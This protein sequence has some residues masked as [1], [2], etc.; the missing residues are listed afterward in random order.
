M[1]TARPVEAAIDD[2]G[3]HGQAEHAADVLATWDGMRDELRSEVFEL[4][5]RTVSVRPDGLGDA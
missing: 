2:V 5:R 3:E 4:G 1:S